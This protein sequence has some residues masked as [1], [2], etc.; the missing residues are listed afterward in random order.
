MEM[1]EKDENIELQQ[2]E[3]ICQMKFE[4]INDNPIEESNKRSIL[5]KKELG[6]PYKYL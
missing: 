5:R 6:F 1:A 4:K 3:T 2:A